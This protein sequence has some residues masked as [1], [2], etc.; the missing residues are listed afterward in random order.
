MGY[1]FPFACTYASWFFDGYEK[2]YRENMKRGA[3]SLQRYFMGV[4]DERMGR[5][6][7][8]FPEESFTYQTLIRELQWEPHKKNASCSFPVSVKE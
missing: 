2:L 6:L 1:G 3:E 5:A 4:V 8:E 7:A